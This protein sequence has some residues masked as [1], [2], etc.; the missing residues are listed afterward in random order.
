MRGRG[1]LLRK[2]WLT[3]MSNPQKAQGTAFETWLVLRAQL[4]GRKAWR[5][6][7]GGSQDAGDI[8]IHIDGPTPAFE[9][10]WLIEAKATANLNPHKALAKAREKAKNADLPHSVEGVAV[11]HKRLTRKDGNTRRTPDGEPIVVYLTL[12]DFLDLI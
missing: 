3:L 11:I 6:A 12:D 7:E 1:R 2:L 9:C 10:H 8:V 4:G 5:L